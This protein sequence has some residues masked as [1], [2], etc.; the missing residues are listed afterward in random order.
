VSRRRT[1]SQVLPD[2]TRA[3]TGA[4]REGA[5]GVRARGGAVRAGAGHAQPKAGALGALVVALVVAA[6]CL[7]V[8]VLSGWVSRAAWRWSGH[9]IPWGLALGLASSISAVLLARRVSRVL[10]FA[11]AAGWAVGLLLLLAG[12]PEGDYVIAN[13]GLGNAFLFATTG[14]VVL[15]AVWQGQGPR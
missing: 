9:L 11:A 13:D 15:A 5:G 7:L 1:S 12:R 8:A 10:G 3:E 4:V 6:G 14:A 2:P